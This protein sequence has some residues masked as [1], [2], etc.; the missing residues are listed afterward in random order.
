MAERGGPSDDHLDRL[1]GVLI[2]QSLISHILGGSHATL[3][4]EGHMTSH[5]ILNIRN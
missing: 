3:F 1:K 2:I 5:R 4:F